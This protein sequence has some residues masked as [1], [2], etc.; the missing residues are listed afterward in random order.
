MAKQKNSKKTANK[1]IDNEIL[2]VLYS[3]LTISLSIIG[4]LEI[5]PAGILLSRLMYFLIGVLENIVFA[6]VIVVALFVLFKKDVRQIKMKY[7][8]GILCFFLAWILLVAAPEDHSIIGMDVLNNFIQNIKGIFNNTLIAPIGNGGILGAILYAL[9][10][11]LF[12]FTGTRIM[13]VMFILMGIIMFWDPIKKVFGFASDTAQKQ[14]VKRNIKKEE[15]EH[16]KEEKKKEKLLFDEDEV[17]YEEEQ[18]QFKFG[19]LTADIIDKKEEPVQTETIQIIDIQPDVVKETKKEVEIESSFL[20]DYAKYRLPSISLLNVVTK[21]S[22]SNTNK[23]AAQENGQKLL[24]IL[25]EFGVKASLV[26]THIGPSV[27]KFELKPDLGVKVSKI[28]NLQNDIKLALAAKDIRIEAPIPSKSAVGIEIPNI[29]KTVVG[30]REILKQVPSKYENSKLLFALGKDLLGQPVYGELNKMPH[31]LIAGAT[32]SGK[33]V[34]VNSIIVSILMRAKP[35]EVKLLLIDPKKV[36]FTAY[37]NI[38]HLIGPIINNGDEANNALKVIVE[39]MDKRYDLFSKAGVRNLAGYNE[40]VEKFPEEGRSKLPWIVV[41]IDELADLMLVAAKEVEA[42]I[43]RITQLARAA[44]IHLVVA[45]QRPS[46]DV[47]TG[48]IKSN[49]P[50]RIAFAVSSGVDSKTILDQYG[51]EKLLGM[52]DMLYVPV[53]EQSPIRVQGVYVSDEEVNR[54]TEFASKQGHPKFDDAFIRLQI[55]EN[56]VGAAGFEN[57]DVLYDEAKQFVI[58]TQKASTSLIQR[59]F[60]IGYQRAARLIDMME[61]NGVVGPSRGSKPR[62]VYMKPSEDE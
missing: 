5:G 36:E 27:T 24:Q 10:S 35:D 44:G 38:P 1:K 62:E 60:S 61:E 43:Q 2:I 21:G 6:G 54:V 13:V 30:L 45:T 58:Q 37:Q 16:K 29:D 42:S 31:L 14:K 59:K 19:Q 32:G 52:G 18:G 49:I 48:V 50:S 40:K 11:A 4:I 47:I 25:E 33:S 56:T 12:D 3:F 46:V 26:D 51:A 41:I 34:C 22:V 9:F 55:V 53:G 8:I 7:S 20:V 57:N 39:E 15:R 28:S 17:S 23:K